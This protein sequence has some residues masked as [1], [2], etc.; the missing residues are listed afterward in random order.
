MF[1]SHSTG[2]DMSIEVAWDFLKE[3]RLPLTRQGPQRTLDEWGIE[4][5]RAPKLVGESL[6]RGMERPFFNPNSRFKESF[7]RHDSRDMI[8]PGAHGEGKFGVDAA[9]EN[10]RKFEENKDMPSYEIGRTIYGDID[11][12]FQRRVLH[13][14]LG[15]LED[16]L[17]KSPNTKQSSA[18]LLDY[19]QPQEMQLVE[20]MVSKPKKDFVRA[21]RDNFLFNELLTDD[22]ITDLVGNNTATFMHSPHNN[23]NKLQSAINSKFL[24]I[25]HNLNIPSNILT[26]Y[27]YDVMR[28]TNYF[29]DSIPKS[30]THDIGPV[31]S[32]TT[33]KEIANWLQNIASGD[34]DEDNYI[35]LTNSIREFVQSEGFNDYM[36]WY[37]KGINTPYRREPRRKNTAGLCPECG[38]DDFY[39]DRDDNVV[40]SD[41]G[42]HM[43]SPVTPQTND[44][45]HNHFKEQLL[46]QLQKHQFADYT[47]GGGFDISGAARVAQGKEEEERA[48]VTRMWNQHT[49]DRKSKISQIIG[50]DMHFIDTIDDWYREGILNNP[51]IQKTHSDNALG[52]NIEGINHEEINA[53]P[54]MRENIPYFLMNEHY[55][56]KRNQTI[57]KHWPMLKTLKQTE[58]MIPPADILHTLRA[59]TKQYRL[60]QFLNDAFFDR[61]L[62]KDRAQFHPSNRYS[63]SGFVVDPD[64]HWPEDNQHVYGD[65]VSDHVKSNI[66]NQTAPTSTY[67]LM[68]PTDKLVQFLEHRLNIR[69]TPGLQK[70]LAEGH[71]LDTDWELMDAEEINHLQSLKKEHN[72]EHMTP[73]QRTSMTGPHVNMT[74]TSNWVKRQGI[75]QLMNSTLLNRIGHLVSGGRTNQ[76]QAFVDQLQQLVEIYGESDIYDKF[77]Y[78][79]KGKEG[80]ENWLK[81]AK[82]SIMRQVANKRLESAFGEVP[83]WIKHVSEGPL[84]TMGSTIMP[85]NLSSRE[86]KQFAAEFDIES[87]PR[88]KQEEI[89]DDL[90]HSHWRRNREEYA[91]KYNMQYALPEQGATWT[92]Q[93]ELREKMEKDE[94]YLKDA[95]T[96]WEKV[97]PEERLEILQDIDKDR[98]HQRADS[99][100]HYQLPSPWGS[101]RPDTPTHLPRSRTPPSFALNPRRVEYQYDEPQDYGGVFP[102][103]VTLANNPLG[104]EMRRQNLER[105]TT[106]LRDRPMPIDSD[107]REDLENRRRIAEGALR[108][109][110]TDILYEG[111]TWPSHFDTTTQ[112]R[113]FTGEQM[114]AQLESMNP[115]QRGEVLDHWKTMYESVKPKDAKAQSQADLRYQLGDYGHNLAY[116]GDEKLGNLFLPYRGQTALFPGFTSEENQLFDSR[117]RQGYPTLEEVQQR[118][119]NIAEMQR[120]WEMMEADRL[121]EE[122]GIKPSGLTG[123]KPDLFE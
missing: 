8:E 2:P 77:D 20:H 37:G 35:D 118:N 85:K 7:T 12:R 34:I 86:L 120:Q 116:V 48:R 42:L 74:N 92:Q 68:T 63:H 3:S 26:Y 55:Q 29:N 78:P 1:I 54:H 117:T 6:R 93:V 71:G 90:M 109:M 91:A 11:T 59:K 121:D 4:Q 41:C 33:S 80:Q 58:H 50:K 97:T 95:P 106:S 114:L 22:E 115:H 62:L 67:Y 100:L 56:S 72:V 21:M 87:L 66:I 98:G 60:S 89:I 84:S 69:F 102:D 43:D 122:K 10:W 53:H 76:G 64:T 30:L 88:N 45:M 5:P 38:S 39:T 51:H 79:W 47:I 19:I 73:I 83:T 108:G 44:E 27:L 81:R 119:R 113:A 112:S 105:L 111:R 70:L 103:P 16:K 18:R 61:D 28:N 24:A 14:V 52:Y 104:Q 101:L 23:L 65:R 40:C 96:N 36:R 99:I 123:L 94:E 49:N 57:P 17:D 107:Y 32:T 25:S 110:P 46:L 31:N 15:E 75:G 82:N 9:L 13:S